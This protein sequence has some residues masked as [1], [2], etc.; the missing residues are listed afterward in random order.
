MAFCLNCFVCIARHFVHS[1]VLTLKVRISREDLQG[2]LEENQVPAGP[3]NVTWATQFVHNLF[4]P[5]PSYSNVI[6]FS[7]IWITV[8]VSGGVL[9]LVII[10]VAVIIGV[11]C[12]NK[13]KKKQQQQQQQKK[14]GNKPPQDPKKPYQQWKTPVRQG[15]VNNTG[16]AG[17]DYYREDSEC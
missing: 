16:V 9:L 7:W 15:F 13:K 10:I 6:H 11:V 8:G 2:R 1:A 12:G 14:D 4:E 5:N 3:F 17:T